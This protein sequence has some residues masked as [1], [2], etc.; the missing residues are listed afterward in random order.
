VEFLKHKKY[1]TMLFNLWFDG[2]KG[3]KKKDFLEAAMPLIETFLFKAI[4][5]QRGLQ[6]LAL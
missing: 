6:E 4:A 5:D 3:M 1:G 2:G